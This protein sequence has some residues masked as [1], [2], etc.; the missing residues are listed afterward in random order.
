[1]GG[2]GDGNAMYRKI[3]YDEEN[4]RKNIESIKGCVRRPT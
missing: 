1:M 2:G 4:L 3:T